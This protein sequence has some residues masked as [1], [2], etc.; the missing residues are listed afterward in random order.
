VHPS[1]TPSHEL[2]W[3]PHQKTS[4]AWR[5]REVHVNF[6]KKLWISTWIHVKIILMSHKTQ[7]PH[8]SENNKTHIL[9]STMTKTRKTLHKPFIKPSQTLHVVHAKTVKFHV[10]SLWNKVKKDHS[11]EYVD[12]VG[13]YMI[14][15]CEQDKFLREDLW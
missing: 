11:C 10:N 4:N 15:F 2:I 13:E 14:F 8:R 3:T 6:I 5:S 1:L 7:V 9:G 12:E